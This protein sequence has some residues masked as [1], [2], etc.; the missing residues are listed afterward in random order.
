MNAL[1]ATGVDT[2]HLDPVGFATWTM[3]R[4]RLAPDIVMFGTLCLLVVSGILTPADG[5]MGFS[6]PAVA[7]IGALFVCAAA[8]QE[9]GALS[10]LASSSSDRSV[11]PSSRSRASSFRR[12]S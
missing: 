10:L 7:T 4:E 11:V 6:N 8:I 12:P 3:A 9:T 2:G 1:L 5:L